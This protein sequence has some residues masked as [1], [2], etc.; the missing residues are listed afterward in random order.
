MLAQLAAQKAFNATTN[1]A[2]TLAGN[3]LYEFEAEY[4][5][6]ETGAVAHVWEVLF[7]GT[8]TITNGLMHTLAHSSAAAAT[9]GAESGAYS[10]TL[11]TAFPVLASVST[12]DTAV[13]R[14]RGRVAINGGGTFI[15]QIALT[16]SAPTTITMQANSF[17]HIWPVGLGAVTNVGNWS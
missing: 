11:G 5:I 8:A 14:I 10:T 17:F 4:F 1:G 9:L 7:A 15:P 6:V 12:A 13:I 2:V 3:T 16:G